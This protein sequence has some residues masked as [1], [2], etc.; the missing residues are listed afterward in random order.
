[1][2]LAEGDT[3]GTFEAFILVQD[4]NPAS[5]TVTVT[6]QLEDGTNITK[7][8]SALANSRYTTRCRDA[9]QVGGGYGFSSEVESNVPIVVER[10]VYWNGYAGGHCW[11]GYPMP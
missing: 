6:C 5:A 3:T 4:P 7:T 2:Y 1:M 11:A 8:E 10:S 9:T